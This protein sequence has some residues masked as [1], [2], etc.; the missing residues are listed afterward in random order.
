MPAFAG[1]VATIEIKTVCNVTAAGSNTIIT[2]LIT[3]WRRTATVLTVPKT[4]IDTIYQSSIYVPVA[5]ALNARSVQARNEIRYLDDAND[6]YT[7]F[8][9]AVVGSI[10]GDAMATQDAAFLLLRTALR[11]RS[12][13]GSKHLG[14]MS[15]SDSTAGTE[16]LFNAACLAR[17]ATIAAAILA[18]FTDSTGNVWLP[19][20]VSRRPPSQL[21]VNPTTVVKNDV[22]AA[23]VKKTIGSMLHR[24]AKSIY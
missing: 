18:G 24:K 22:T 11:G 7:S 6:P 15:E 5:A 14:P 2:N 9:H 10:A 20:I 21:S 4:P 17:L 19:V 16:N 8:S 13:R 1:V 23:L 3:H 12:Y